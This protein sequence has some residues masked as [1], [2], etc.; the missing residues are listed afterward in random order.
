MFVVTVGLAWPEEAFQPIL[1]TSRDNVNMQMWDA[2]AYTVI[3]GNEGTFS[4]EPLLDSKHQQLN[5]R[6]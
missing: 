5:V 1:L 4:Q 2:L 3:D 6:K